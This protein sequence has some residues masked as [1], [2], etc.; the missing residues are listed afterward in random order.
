MDSKKCNKCGEVKAFSE[1]HLSKL[2]RDGRHSH[3][4]ACQRESGREFG[5]RTAA[6]NE[7]A[8][9]DP[10]GKIKECSQCGEEKPLL[11]FGKDKYKKDGY[12]N[13]CKDCRRP[14]VKKSAMAYH[15]RHKE[16]VNAA[17]RE[18]YARNADRY[19]AAA[20][21][22]RLDPKHRD[23]ILARERAANRRRMSKPENREKARKAC[24]SHYYRNKPIYRAAWSR[25]KAAKVS[26]TPAWA[27]MD[28][29]QGFYDE[30]ERLSKETGIKHHVD[31]IIPLQGELVSGLHVEHNLQV[32]PWDENIRK[33]NH[34]DPMDCEL[35]T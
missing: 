27:D 29:I 17:Q 31:H 16:K 9:V 19:N 20:R 2:G 22:K 33:S 32:I 26:Q 13:I 28:L 6:A 24:L 25:W 12:R 34:Y 21:A 7:A 8:P 5:R 11:E 14:A 30:A 23:H 15:Y 18:K 3:C 4:K 35:F 10:A 1:F